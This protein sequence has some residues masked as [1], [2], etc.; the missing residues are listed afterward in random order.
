MEAVDL[1]DINVWLA[2]AD[3]DHEHHERAREYWEK[4]AAP[5]LAFTRITMLGLIRLLTNRHVMKG[6]PFSVQEAW[7]AY[8]TFLQLPEVLFLNDPESAE[9]TMRAWTDSP[10]FVSSRLTDAWI[11]AIAFTTGSRVVSFDSD[12]QGFANLSFYH[13]K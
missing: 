4:E 11:A 7:L 1:P 8:E 12:F 10:T 9:S 5:T 3:P 6:A 13:L 2:L